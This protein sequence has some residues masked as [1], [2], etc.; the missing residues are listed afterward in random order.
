VQHPLTAR[1][2]ASPNGVI[3][4][5]SAGYAAINRHLWVL[6]LPI[7]VDLI[8]W[9]GP[10]VSY[11]PLVD[12]TV[13]RASEWARQVTP[14]PRRA[15]RNPELASSVDD[16]RQWLITRT[17]EVNV[18]SLVAR[19]P[20]ALPI[21]AAPSARGDFAF[22]SDWG[23]GVGLLLGV[24]LSGLFLGG[25][26]YSGVAAAST[27]RPSNPLTLGRRTPRQVARVL[28]LVAALIG[29]GLLLG[30]P[31]V[32]L[33]AFTAVVA[34]I[35]ATLGVV[36][37][38]VAGA[39]VVLHLFFALDAIFVSD[40]GPLQAIQRSVAVVRRHLWPSLALMLLTWLILAGMSRVWDVVASNVQAPFGTGLSILGNA[41]IASGLIAASMI[42]YTERVES[43]STAAVA[44]APSPS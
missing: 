14:G 43:P 10:H 29:T 8:L 35:V 15:P 41:Y 11:S 9:F 17:G 44:S 6:L 2:Q 32:L 39:C 16:A 22:V 40:V 36:L 7:L 26:F 33:I 5:L 24:A 18:L 23:A 4:A 12:P 21:L 31:V 25:C 1:R 27:G 28:G 3:E 30:L 38:G 42:F 34:P 37:I 13:T 20:V 19:G